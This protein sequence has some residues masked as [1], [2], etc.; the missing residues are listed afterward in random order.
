[1]SDKQTILLV[2]DS[3]ND[4]FLM[5]TAF[6]KAEF[7]VLLQEACSGTQAIAYL[8]G[9]SAYG[10]RSRFPLPVVMLLDLNMPMQNG[11]DV[12]T[13]VRSQSGLKRLS[14]IVLSA[15]TRGEDIERACDLGCNSFLV[16]P[17]SLDELIDMVRC[18]RGWVGINSYPSLDGDVGPGG[19]P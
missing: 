5:R 19:V 13:W 14:V 2:D 8:K 15:S 10:D 7:G 17:P 3:E 12:L 18:L 9:D 16:K 11:F 6:K 4:L 1:M